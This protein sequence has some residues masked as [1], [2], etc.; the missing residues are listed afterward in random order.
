MNYLR[1]IL[2]IGRALQ[3]PLQRLEYR[4]FSYMQLPPNMFANTHLLC[5]SHISVLY[6][7]DE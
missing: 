4:S 3:L 2:G 7:R 6:R 5:W 1:N